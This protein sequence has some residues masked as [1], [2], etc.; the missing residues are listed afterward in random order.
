MR[1][2]I[3]AGL[4][5]VGMLAGCGGDQGAS[6][7]ESTNPGSPVV[8]AQASLGPVLGPCQRNC[9]AQYNR[10]MMNAHGN[11]SAE[12]TCDSTWGNC[13][14]ECPPTQP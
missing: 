14:L 11:Q 6:M 12:L 9:N 4:M 8:S 7:E 5:A 10:C 1:V 13:L 2:A 3:I